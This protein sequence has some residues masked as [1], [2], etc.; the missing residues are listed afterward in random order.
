VLTD[1]AAERAV[2]AGIFK[3]GPDAYNDIADILSDGTFTDTANSIIYKSLKRIIEADDDAEIDIPS[4][5]AAAEQLDMGYIF[6]KAEEVKHLVA[7]TNTPIHLS[8]VRK[9]AAKIRKLEIQRLLL[10][11]LDATKEKILDEDGDS[12][13]SHIIGIAENDIFDFS[14]LINSSDDTQ[15]ELLVDGLTEYMEYLAD[16]PVEQMGI[17]SGY[18]TYDTAIG[19]GFRRGSVSLIG[20]RTKCGKSIICINIANHIT[21][22]LDIPVLYLDTEML[23]SDQRHRLMA[24]LTETPIDDIETGQYGLNPMSRKRVLDMSNKIENKK[25]P[26]YYRN[27]SGKPFEETMAIMRRWITK[28]V[29]MNPDRTAKDCLVI[30]DYLKLMSS[31]GITADLKE[32]QLLGFMMTGLHNLAVRYSVPVLT[33]IQLNRDG[34]TK[35]S[36]EAASGSDRVVWLCSNFSLYK[37]KS[38]E[39]LAEDGPENGNRKLVPLVSRHGPGLE[40]GDYINMIMDGKY[41]KI[42][43][44]KTALESNKTDDGFIVEDNDDESIPF[45]G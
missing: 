5:Y 3:Y 34:I 32:Y 38:D 24:R 26:I 20:A 43:E 14:S 31:E 7:L 9:F 21:N 1:L 44:G 10:N 23:K 6:K 42:I 17:S 18:G 22:N 35:E 29:G 28:V 39:E 33:T 41:A 16:N 37:F 30:F 15:P 40:N 11:Q 36:T 2:L 13:L 19:G 25:M 4:I 8:N 45:T 12:P 27:I